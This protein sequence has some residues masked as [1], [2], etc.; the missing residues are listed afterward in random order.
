M[1]IFLVFQQ[2]YAT[3]PIRNPSLY[4]CCNLYSYFL[5]T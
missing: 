1:K 5:T 4:S 2:L 3:V